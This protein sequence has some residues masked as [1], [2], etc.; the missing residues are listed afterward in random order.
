MINIKGHSLSVYYGSVVYS[1]H[2]L[3]V[4]GDGPLGIIGYAYYSVFFFLTKVQRS[5]GWWT[6]C[7]MN[8]QVS[9]NDPSGEG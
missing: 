9:S 8:M 1:L 5:I 4:E 2:L 6:N 7:L 3:V